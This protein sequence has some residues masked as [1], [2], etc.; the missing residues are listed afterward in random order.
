V[1][2]KCFH[3]WNYVVRG[4]THKQAE[5]GKIQGSRGVEAEISLI[6]IFYLA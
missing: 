3:H 2:K 6:A 1:T 5:S 4:E